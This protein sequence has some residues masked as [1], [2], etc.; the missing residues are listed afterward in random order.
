MWRKIIASLRSG[1]RIA[2]QHYG[3]RDGWAG[4]AGVTC[5]DRALVL[6]RLEGLEIELRE[7]EESDAVTPRGA[8]KHWPLG[9][10]GAR[11]P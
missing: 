7:E 6:Q 4:R 1:G 5:H 9:P 3:D 2:G 10:R 11:R 8:T